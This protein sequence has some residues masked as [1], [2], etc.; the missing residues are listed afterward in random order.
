MEL[1]GK[2]QNSSH[3]QALPHPAH[4]YAMRA[5]CL[6]V[7]ALVSAAGTRPGTIPLNAGSKYFDE[8]E[9][10][11]TNNWNANV[12]ALAERGWAAV[13][14]A[15]PADPSFLE[16]VYKAARI[17]HVLGRDLMVESLYA[18]AMTACEALL[19]K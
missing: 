18:E 11:L 1:D 8:V 16:G 6:I 13:H 10:I 17:F 2:G 4:T 14:T 3:V 19:M 9:R 7:V 15:G 5:A 12:I